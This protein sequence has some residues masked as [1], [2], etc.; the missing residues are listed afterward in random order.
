M[1]TD[2]LLDRTVIILSSYN[3][4][5]KKD[6]AFDLYKLGIK[7]AFIR[8]IEQCK[9]LPLTQQLEHIT[10]EMKEKKGGIA[11][12]MEHESSQKRTW[13]LVFTL[14]TLAL[15]RKQNLPANHPEILPIDKLLSGLSNGWVHGFGSIGLGLKLNEEA[16]NNL[17]EGM[18]DWIQNFDINQGM[19]TQHEILLALY[20]VSCSLEEKLSS[21][22]IVP[23]RIKDEMTTIKTLVA[24]KFNELKIKLE[25]E[26]SD[27]RVDLSTQ[28]A[29]R[30]E[31]VSSA[32]QV[33]LPKEV[34][35]YQQFKEQLE[36]LQKQ[37][38]ELHQKINNFPQE[39][40]NRL[41]KL[42][43]LLKE[44]PSANIEDKMSEF[45]KKYN[46][47]EKFNQLMADL[48]LTESEKSGWQE[49]FRYQHGSY[50]EQVMSI[51]W[52]GNWGLPEFMG[53]IQSDM[54][55][56][57]V[58]LCKCESAQKPLK[59][60]RAEQQKLIPDEEKPSQLIDSIE[61]NLKTLAGLKK[62]KIDSFDKQLLD[63]MK[64]ETTIDTLGKINGDI[65]E[66][67]ENLVKQKM[68]I[69]S[70]K[71]IHEKMELLKKHVNCTDIEKTFGLLLDEVINTLS[72]MKHPLPPDLPTAKK[73]AALNSSIG[74]AL[75]NVEGIELS[76]NHIVN[77]SSNHK[78]STI[79]LVNQFVSSKENTWGHKLLLIFS[80]S[81][82]K[83]FNELKK[84]LTEKTTETSLN[85]IKAVLGITNEPSNKKEIAKQFK[86]LQEKVKET[87]DNEYLEDM[88]VFEKK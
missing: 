86:G 48:E 35:L 85:N 78:L 20:A 63:S 70:L 3:G 23:K 15:E 67:K 30:S 38:E 69:A 7:N 87:L 81:Y 71:N 55:S 32:L 84:V 77:T 72:Y 27:S 31:Q 12:K 9:L 66:L 34:T 10:K 62:I 14:A 83:M 16:I 33:L 37:Q 61:K 18:K 58:L 73:I 75:E 52:T 49:Y 29:T 5:T 39:K 26:L 41:L 64:G 44:Q 57:E 8:F 50:A 2:A 17:I 51:L 6:P 21:Y 80:P 4:Q 60:I 13:T 47:Q 88:P 59:A 46:T 1:L 82:K 36:F 68:I 56:L 43:Q 53:G 28:Q 76:I 45:W 25:N 74:R 65:E 54:I 40:F 11:A 42:H 22:R 79:K 24:N 19:Q